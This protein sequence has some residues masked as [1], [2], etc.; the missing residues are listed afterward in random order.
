MGEGTE[1]RREET[2]MENFYYACLYDALNQPNQHAKKKT[3]ID[4]LQAKIVVIH[5]AKLERGQV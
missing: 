1:K 3:M 5:T 2:Q 4:S